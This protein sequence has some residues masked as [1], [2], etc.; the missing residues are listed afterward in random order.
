M[1][2]E[3]CVRCEG[4]KGIASFV[5]DNQQYAL[6]SHHLSRFGNVLD[7]IYDCLLTT[8]FVTI[9]HVVILLCTLYVVESL[10]S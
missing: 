4:V 3:E 2:G 1:D 9:V 6:V 5:R 8:Q 7:I 10:Q